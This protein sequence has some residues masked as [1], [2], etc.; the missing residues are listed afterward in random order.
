MTARAKSA[1]ATEIAK[2]VK[3]NAKELVT[4]PDSHTGEMVV[5]RGRIFNINSNEEFQIWI[6]G[7]SHEAVYVVMAQPYDDLFE[8]NYVTIYGLV[9]GENC[10]TNS[11]G[12]EICQPLIAGVFYEKK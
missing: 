10:G 12:A 9:A 1:R 3:I 11:F 7:A 4:Y 2:Y 6:D 8:N 5:I